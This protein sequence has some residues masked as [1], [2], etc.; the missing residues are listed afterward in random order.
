MATVT[1]YTAAHMLEIENSTIVDGNISGSDLILV[2]R[3]GTQI[4]AGNVRGPQGIQGIP[5]PLT[6][7]QADA[8]YMN[9]TGDVIRDGL[10]QV[11]RTGTGSAEGL[12]LLHATSPFLTFYNGTTRTGYIQGSNDIF[13]IAA[14]TDNPMR[15]ITNGVE[16]IR[17]RT[18]T[19]DEILTV[20]G[21]P[22]ALI[23]MRGSSPGGTVYNY[24]GKHGG[25]GFRATGFTGDT[26]L[27]STVGDVRIQA[28]NNVDFYTNN[29]FAGT[30]I[31]G[32]DFLLSKSST[33]IHVPG[34]HWHTDWRS[35][36][37]TTDINNA[38]GI[39]MNRVGAAAGTG[40]SYQVFEVNGSTVGSIQRTSSGVKYNE[41][42]DY[43]T[44]DVKGPVTNALERIVLLN[45]VR[46]V[47]KD[48]LAQTE[49]E[50]FVAHEVAQVV[51]EAVS[52]E[53]DAVADASNSEI[54]GIPVGQPILQQLDT[55]KLIP[56]L[57]SAVK[58][59]SAKVDE[60]QARLAPA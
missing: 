17:L 52:G 9:I 48:D 32:G 12:R 58:E 55:K 60:L 59:L 23:Y 31:S 11:T 56:L 33:Q 30:F 24:F 47:Y 35:L 3:G 8:R 15:F 40:E 16:Q 49:V 20:N 13:T 54:L 29:A 34:L 22:D 57:V 45:P 27:Q 42:S 19:A 44:K 28:K 39:H 50:T 46:A 41:T 51:P 18:G 53:K 38:V 2:T 4:N 14:E 10:L 1:G 25:W 36:R 21:N 26:L 5:G 7:A 37:L 6:Q 43:R